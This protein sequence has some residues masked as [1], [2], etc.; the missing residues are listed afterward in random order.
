[1]ETPHWATYTEILSR[2]LLLCFNSTISVVIWDFSL[3]LFFFFSHK[4]NLRMANEEMPIWRKTRLQSTGMYYQSAYTGSYRHERS[5]KVWCG[6]A[7]CAASR[8]PGLPH[9]PTKAAKR[10]SGEA[11]PPIL[12]LTAAAPS[13]ESAVQGLPKDWGECPLG[14]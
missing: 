3:T 12:C 1:M 9:T 8:D 7:A 2:V 13:H 6:P 10:G 14:W 4:S 5:H 11:P